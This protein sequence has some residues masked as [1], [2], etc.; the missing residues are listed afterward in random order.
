MSPVQMTARVRERP[1]SFYRWLCEQTRRDEPIGDFARDVAADMAFP[2]DARFAHDLEGFVMRWLGG[3]DAVY[4]AFVAA[5]REYR[6]SEEG[7]RHYRRCVR[8]YFRTSPRRL[9]PSPRG[10]RSI[11]PSLR[12]FVLERDGFRCRRCGSG[13]DDGRLV[14]DH[15]D[16][17]ALGGGSEAE[18]LQV[19]CDP[20][21]AGKGAREPHPHDRRPFR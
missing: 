20:C 9:A 16:P 5:L 2:K 15:I 17:V 3:H 12:A 10:D 6:R 13:P 8:R 19:L 1:A 4:Q 21:N 14:I 7:R 18:N 11:S